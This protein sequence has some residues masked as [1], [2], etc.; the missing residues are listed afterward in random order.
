MKKT[1]FIIFTA[2]LFCSCSSWGHQRY[3]AFCGG[4]FD[5]EINI[6]AYA[7]SP[8]DFQQGKDAV[9]AVIEKDAMLFDIYN[10]YEG[11]NNLK[12]V[13]DNAGRAPVKADPAIL[14][15]MELSVDFYRET[16]GAVNIGLGAVFGIWREYRLEGEKLPPMD[17]LMAAAWD[18][19]PEGLIIDREAGTIFIQNAGH[20][21][22]AGAIAK[23]FTAMRAMEAAK[24]AGLSSVL[25]DMG[26][27][28]FAHG[29]PMDGRDSWAVGIQS[30]DLEG[31]G[32]NLLGTVYV[33][34]MA[35]ASSGAY[36]RY[37]TVDGTRYHHIIDPATLLPADIFSHVTVMHANAALA[38]AYA[39]ALFIL[40]LD[41]GKALI[42]RAGGEALWVSIDGEIE[43]T[44][45]LAAGFRF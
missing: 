22:D 28:V 34:D 29:K 40:P 9:I 45:G 36:R 10:S 42:E 19:F 31:G 17:E 44:G 27:D 1:A 37:Y 3:S 5:T 8:A 35:V 32:Q 18:D 30:P 2:I 43:V 41:E 38:D 23:G 11:V 14:D 26:G 16:S 13:N 21:L 25:I 12:T 33:N 4:L 15:L 24:A 20:S 6:T 7:R 39:T